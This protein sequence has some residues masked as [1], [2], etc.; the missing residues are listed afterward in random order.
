MA[1]GR[2]GNQAV[3]GEMEDDI[4][5]NAIN[6]EREPTMMDMMRLFMEE[7]R[8]SDIR[9][10]EA[11]LAREAETRRE[12][13]AQ[14]VVAEQRQ[15]DQ[16]LA[17]IR[18][19]AELGKEASRVHRE[20]QLQDRKRDRALFSVPAFKEGDDLEDFFVMIEGRMEAAEIGRDE[21]VPSISSKLTG[22]LA[23]TWREI[24]LATDDY[25]VARTRL[26]EGSGYTAMTAADRFFG[27]KQD[28]C[29]G[30][31]A[32][33]LY[34]KGQQLV[35]RMM[36]PSIQTPEQEFALLRGWVGTVIPKRAR[37][38]MD[39]RVVNRAAELIAALQDYLALEGDTGSGQTA[40]FRGK[41]VLEGQGDRRAPITCYTC[42]KAGHRA[43]D[44]WQGKGGASAPKNGAGGVVH[45]VVCYTC[46]VE[47]H[48]TPQCPKLQKGEV[49]GNKDARPKPIKRVW[50][51]QPRCVQL[52]GEV[53]GHAVPILLDS[54]ASISVV[55]ES[56]VSPERLAGCTVSVRPFGAKE[57][58]VLPIADIPFKIG[59][60]EWEERVAVA[61][62]QEGVDEEVL[63]G[64]DLES[65]RG[66][67]LVLLVN[68]ARQPNVLRV[69]TRAQAETERQ[70]QQKEAWEE[71]VEKPEAKALDSLGI[72]QDLGMEPEVNIEDVAEER[73]QLRKEKRGEPE[74]V[75]PPVNKGKGDR[76]AL[77]AEV[78]ADPTLKS[79]RELADKGESGF[80]WDEDLLYKDVSTHVLEVVQLLVLPKGFRKKVLELAH[81]GMS[82][83]GARRVTALLRQR[84]AWPG[85]GQD[86]I[87][88]CRSCPTCQQCAKAPARKVPMQEREVLSE[89][90]ESVAVDIVG[91]LPKGK[92]GCRFLLT[93]V[94]MAS[95]WPEAIPLRSITARAVAE[96]L[97]DMFSRTGIPLRL[98]SD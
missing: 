21:W 98:L 14:Q 44:C 23:S 26:L 67:D 78:K 77:V 83:M 58:M 53:D 89:P 4:R 13:A 63:Y 22:R 71:A 24:T 55:P 76:A 42:G 62:K 36:A 91:P 15:Y 74:L 17:L 68:K 94:C 20:T 81:E 66:L 46:G 35:R 43:A 16:Q 38:A 51:S 45:K 69:T 64:L 29:K 37:A 61:P 27:F 75:I 47:G 79:W 72:S 6:G 48:K 2:R 86:V 28:Q 84:F 52:M 3:E 93:A 65:E 33:E 85:M 18:L 41:N 59:E 32:R 19:Q 49:A 34:Q 60:L 25:A 70:I 40:V 9:R 8:Q 87:R 92:G 10:E 90:F 82:H 5:A 97:V 56:L 96:G 39:A 88:H 80:A 12:L 73:Y 95:R 54:G 31:S 7:H 30:L 57:F 50:H 1:R 11:R